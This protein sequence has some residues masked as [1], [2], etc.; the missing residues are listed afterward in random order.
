MSL[1]ENQHFDESQVSE[2]FI[3]YKTSEGRVIDS[4][5]EKK[6]NNKAFTYTHKI[7]IEKNGQVLNKKRAI[8]ASEY[9]ELEQL[10][11]PQVSTLHSTRLCT[12]DDGL[13][14]I[15]DYY[16]QVDGKP[17]TCII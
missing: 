11:L 7:S 13:Y 15:I 5:V 12:I 2:T 9:I 4:S 10:K 6:G 3:N 1:G 14:M 16:E 17:M 8:S